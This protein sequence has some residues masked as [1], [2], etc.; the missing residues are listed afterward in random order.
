MNGLAS[1]TKPRAGIQTL[2]AVVLALASVHASAKSDHALVQVVDPYM[3]MYTGPGRGYP[4][5]YVV[6]Q[7]D[8]IEI[9]KRKTDWF[10][11]R[12][13]HRYR[14]KTGWVH[15][16]QMTRTLTPGGGWAV[17]PNAGRDDWLQRRLEGG[18]SGGSFGGANL[19][20]GYINFAITPNISVQANGS[21]I[22][23]DFSDGVMGTF[24]V[25]ERPFPNW[26]LSPY[27]ALGTGVLHVEQHSTLVQA[28]DRTDA[29]VNA[30]AGASFYVTRRFLLK[31]EYRYNVVL[32]SR[33]DN[34]EIH[35]WAVGFSVFF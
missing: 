19:V 31:G 17:F 22:L 18:V 10:K 25:M 33:D 11:I 34:E 2:L 24:S 6:E 16:D 1:N 14:P 35:E 23:G 32:T 29:L 26:R 20:T 7:G 27:V 12:T 13:E 8:E 21:Q 30:G 4:M 5:F 15:I 28:E 9:L 3:D